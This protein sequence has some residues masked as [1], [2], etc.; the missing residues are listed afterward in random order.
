[1]SAVARHFEVLNAVRDTVAGIGLNGV[2]PV[3]CVV[4]L[5]PLVDKLLKR[6]ELHLPAVVM[7]PHLAESINGN[8]MTGTNLHD[9][10]GY[11]V[12]VCLVEN[13]DASML[14]TGSGINRYLYLRE[15][16]VKAFH[17]KRLAGVD[18]VA[19]CLVEPAPVV[20]LNTWVSDSL[21]VS[22]FVVRAISREQR[23]T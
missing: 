10:Y 13:A 8:G 17:N 2:L 6:G 11:P 20:E 14:L 19:K 12:T 22:A 1:M 23:P 7:A 15:Q 18:S 4:G 5:L 16:L 3:N 9:D 21:Y